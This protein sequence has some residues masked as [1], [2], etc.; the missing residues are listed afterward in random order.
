MKNWLSKLSVTVSKLIIEKKKQEHCGT[1]DNAK[2][3]FC[4]LPACTGIDP[5][6][7]GEFPKLSSYWIVGHED[8]LFGD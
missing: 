2:K 1:F 4:N 7:S 3:H 8:I 5:R 6:D